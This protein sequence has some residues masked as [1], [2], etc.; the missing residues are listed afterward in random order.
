[1]L[2][3]V[4]IAFAALF[5]CTLAQPV[6]AQSWRE[7]AAV[8]AVFGHCGDPCVITY[9]PGGE[10]A[11]FQAAGH[12]VRAGAKR[13]VIIDGPCL[14]ACA[15]FADIAR[16]R[17]C[18]TPRA[19]FGFHKASVYAVQG[20]S[21]LRL[22]GREDPPQSRDIRRWVKRQGGF[23]VRGMRMMS[24]KQAARFWRRCS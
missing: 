5:S 2:R 4:C 24:N 12:A 16:A 15:I 20:P 21:E 17:V 1:M 8:A 11:K 6:Q 3:V 23:P 14:S 13:L 10:V 19:Q 9:S 18:I 22:V 7:S